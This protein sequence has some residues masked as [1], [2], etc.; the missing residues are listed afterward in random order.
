M[1][2][3]L[4]FLFS[5]NLK[6]GVGFTAGCLSSWKNNWANESF[7]DRIRNKDNFPVPEPEKRQ[8]ESCR[9]SVIIDQHTKYF[10]WARV[11]GI[12]NFLS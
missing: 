2:K 4:E 6:S 9:K 11:G 10:K 8:Q 7:V 12:G 3:S 5:V 1:Q